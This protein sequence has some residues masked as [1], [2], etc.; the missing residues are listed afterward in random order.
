VTPDQLPERVTDLLNHL[1][2]LDVAEW[3]QM[4]RLAIRSDAR[5]ATQRHSSLQ[6]LADER[7]VLAQWYVH[8]AVTSLVIRTGNKRRRLTRSDRRLLAAARAS[9]LER[10]LAL[11]V[12]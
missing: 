1:A 5:L 7:I 9:A 11:L 2:E 4:G 3:L 12:R 8:D 6:L 10:S